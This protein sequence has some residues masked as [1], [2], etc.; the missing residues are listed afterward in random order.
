[1][2]DAETARARATHRA[3]QH[4]EQQVALAHSRRLND[5]GAWPHVFPQHGTV[6]RNAGQ[7][8]VA[9]IED[10]RSAVDGHDVRRAMA[11]SVYWTKPSRLASR[12]FVGD[13]L[14]INTE[15]NEVVDH[16]GRARETPLGDALLRIVAGV[17]RPD[18]L[19]VA[20]VERVQQSSSAKRIHA[21]IGAEGGRSTWTGAA[22][23]LPEA[24]RV[25]MPPH[26][27]ASFDAV[28]RDDLIVAAL[29][30]RED[31][32]PAHGARRPSRANRMPPQRNRRRL[33]PVRVDPHAVDHTVALRSTKAW[34]CNRK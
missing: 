10:L 5:C 22:V 28:R 31:H 2:I 16:C 33:G 34:P 26:R 27:L 8:R 9:H 12:T 13:E 4:A 18:H 14:T 20:R 1:M 3:A 25:S 19:A 17:S 23:G 7:T 29:F 11:P 24:S 6:G 32:I 30:L 21:T 15:N